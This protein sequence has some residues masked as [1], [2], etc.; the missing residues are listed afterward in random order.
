MNNKV[1]MGL[2]VLMIGVLVGWYALGGSLPTVDQLK[3]DQTTISPTFSPQAKAQTEE[4]TGA[5]EMMDKGGVV[6]RVVVMYTDGGF[7]PEITTVKRGNVVTFV[8][9]SSRSMWVASAMHPTHQLLP[10]FDQLKSVGTSGTYEYTFT[11]VG[12]WKYHNHMNPTDTGTVVV[13]E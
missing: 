11:K 5:S 8:N 3:S 13:V 10:G 1:F 9:E 4:S 7:G 2:I 6:A 12:T